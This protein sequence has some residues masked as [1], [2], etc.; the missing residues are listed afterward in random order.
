MGLGLAI[1]SFLAG[2][3]LSRRGVNPGIPE[4]FLI[5]KGDAAQQVRAGVLVTLRA[6]QAGYTKRDS[7]ALPAF[8]EQL[9]PKD[10]DILLLGTD[11]GEWIEGYRSVE[12]LIANDWRYWGDV[13]L[14]VNDAMV[15]SSGDVAWVTTV[16]TVRAGTSTGRPIRFTAVLTRSKDRW[17]FRELQFHWEDAPERLS[18]LIGRSLRRWFAAL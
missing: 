6:F 18:Q 15:F 2:W 1:L 8:M 16:G 7:S 14:E 17:L 12:D 5:G 3:H 10:Q 11:R 13:R 4:R 9:F